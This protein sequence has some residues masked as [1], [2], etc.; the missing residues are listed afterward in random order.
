[1][2][3]VFQTVPCVHM[4]WGA[5][6]HIAKICSDK[7]NEKNILIVTDAEI[8]KAG[9]LQS[10]IQSLEDNK[11]NVHIFDG[12]SADP[13]ETVLLECVDFAKKAEIDCVLG[14]GVDHHWMLPNSL[15]FSLKAIK[16][17][18]VSMA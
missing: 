17:F 16:N 14:V 15:P 12:V 2:Q 11:F 4:E 3:F 8:R 10:A 1:M 7:F 6:K 5:S 13:S 18:Q 9:I